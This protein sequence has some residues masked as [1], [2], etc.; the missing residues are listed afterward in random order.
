MTTL[1]SVEGKNAHMR[2]LT[3]SAVLL[4]ALSSM[5]A[6]QDISVDQHGRFLAVGLDH[7]TVTLSGFSSE[8]ATAT[9]TMIGHHYAGVPEDGPLCLDIRP[10]SVEVDLTDG[11]G[12]AS[13]EFTNR[14]DGRYRLRCR[15]RADDGAGVVTDV[16]RIQTIG[17]EPRVGLDPPMLEPN[18]TAQV[19]VSAWLAS[20]YSNGT[21]NDF[22]DPSWRDNPPQIAAGCG[23]ISLSQVG[24]FSVE[25]TQTGSVGITTF[26][27]VTSEP[28]E[29]PVTATAQDFEAETTLTVAAAVPALP[30]AGVLLLAALL[31]RGRPWSRPWSAQ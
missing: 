11:A 18:T 4:A 9:V 5:A 23:E 19:E 1:Q 2:I 7:V 12:E 16:G 30:A 21:E 29:C 8:S 22:P 28:I 25:R 20:G 24:E 27:A 13:W 6:A 10:L 14:F 15:I 31:I 17:G 26:E 3:L